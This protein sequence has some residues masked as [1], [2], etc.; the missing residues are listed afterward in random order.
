MI[1][2][3]DLGALDLER[4]R[5]ARLTRLLLADA[6]LLDHLRVLVA[7]VALEVDV[8]VEDEEA[9]VLQLPERVDLGE[10]QVVAQE[11]LDQRGDDR[12]Q[13]VQIVAGDAHGGDRLLGAERRERH[14]RRQVR[15]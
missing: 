15:P 14:E 8:P 7:R 2:G 13:A 11:D 4:R 6:E 5:R 12:R 1:R 10:R 9:A 3:V